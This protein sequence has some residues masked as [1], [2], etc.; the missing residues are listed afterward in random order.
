MSIRTPVVILLC[1]LPF[2][3]CSAAT[4]AG[5]VQVE[6]IKDPSLDDM[7]AYQVTIPAKWHFQGVIYEG[8]NCMPSPSDVFR[9]SSP[10]GL[11]YVADLPDLSWRYGTGPAA[12]PPAQNTCLPVNRAM[13]GEEFLRYLAGV[14]HVVYEGAEPVPA[15][16]TAAAQAELEKVAASM[17]GLY[18]SHNMTPPKGTVEL[19]RA[20]VTYKNGT[21]T[22]RGRFDTR[23]GCSISFVPGGKILG[24]RGGL[25]HPA[26]MIDG[27]SST[28]NLCTAHTR[29][30]TAPENQF[31][32][33]LKEW[34]AG[35][36]GARQPEK[37][38]AQAYMKRSAEQTQNTMK[39]IADMTRRDMDAHAQQFAHDQAVRG[40][41]HQ[42]FLA[43]M[44]R[45][46]D[47][48]MSN[49]NASM[50][51]RSTA[52]S[53]MVD[54]ALDRR[55]VADPNTGMMTKIPQA[56][57]AWSNGTGEMYVSKYPYDNPNG[58]LPGNWTQQ[59]VVHGDGTP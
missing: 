20:L 26:Q 7:T 44:Q 47:I 35:G 18:A 14:M 49:A 12:A 40:E 37:P 22:M 48:S 5:G 9:A 6:A 2:T 57:T 4:S 16:E 25:G 28:V 11:S 39:M 43:T 3:G 58:S 42:Q 10:D 33:L 45:G 23:I 52:A 32:A 50:N 17:A 41:M 53:D 24:P 38:W 19:A 21:F 1:A 59:A 8:G 29:Y 34:D 15:A 51:A 27:P 54:Y 46:T 13:T 55:T 36:M 56:A 30:F 31:A